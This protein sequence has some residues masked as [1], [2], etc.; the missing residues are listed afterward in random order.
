MKAEIGD[1]CRI[2]YDVNAAYIKVKVATPV[3]TLRPLSGDSLYSTAESVDSNAPHRLSLLAD[4]ALGNVDSISSTGGSSGSIVLSTASTSSALAT[5]SSSEDSLA[6]PPIVSGPDSPTQHEGGKDD[7]GTTVITEEHSDEDLVYAHY[8]IGPSESTQALR[9]FIMQ[10]SER[11]RK[12]RRREFDEQQ[13]KRREEADKVYASFRER[14]RCQLLGSSGSPATAYTPALAPDVICDRGS[15]SPATPAFGSWRTRTPSPLLG[16]F[17]GASS[18]VDTWTF[19]P[20]NTGPDAD[21]ANPSSGNSHG[22]GLMVHYDVGEDVPLP[23]RRAFTMSPSEEE[24]KPVINVEE[25]LD[26]NAER[27]F[28]EFGI[29]Y[30]TQAL[31]NFIMKDCEKA[32]ERRRENFE[33]SM[34]VRQ[35]QRAKQVVAILN[36]SGELDGA[37]GSP[38]TTQA[39]G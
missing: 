25:N 4:L 18:G 19:L 3:T 35:A 16:N 39:C 11:V 31:R 23:P 37:L 6:S 8:E 33:A 1:H 26:E 14:R 38:E 20:G 36:E 28:H 15:M 21:Y 22:L 24:M 5:Q 34:A 2:S 10:D 7:C 29:S 12:E 32:A 30:S 9:D 13:L 27:D 17:K